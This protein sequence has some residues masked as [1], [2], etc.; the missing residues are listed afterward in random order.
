MCAISAPTIETYGAL[1]HR[2]VV[3]HPLV[4]PGIVV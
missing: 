3:L 1:V 4:I 2:K